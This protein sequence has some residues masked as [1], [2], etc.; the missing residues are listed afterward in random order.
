MWEKFLIIM[1]SE[2]CA[3]L[4]LAKNVLKSLNGVKLIIALFAS[5]HCEICKWGNGIS[6][7]LYGN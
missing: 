3:K 6:A 1:P 4:D 7:D 5:V 2:I